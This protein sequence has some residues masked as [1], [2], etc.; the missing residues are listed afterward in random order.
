MYPRILQTPDKVIN[1]FAK[2]C[3]MIITK[4]Y[5]AYVWGEFHEYFIENFLNPFENLKDD[6]DSDDE[7]TNFDHKNVIF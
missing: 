6:H 5:D 2:K 7:D 4:S 1:V 3:S